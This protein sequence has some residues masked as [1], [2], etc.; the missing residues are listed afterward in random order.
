MLQRVRRESR[1]PRLLTVHHRFKATVSSFISHSLHCSPTIVEMQLLEIGQTSKRLR[2]RKRKSFYRWLSSAKIVP[3]DRPNKERKAARCI[4]VLCRDELLGCRFNVA[5]YGNE[6]N[7][8]AWLLLK[9]P[10]FFFLH[11]TL[12]LRK[13]LDH[14]IFITFAMMCAV[15]WRLIVCLGSYCANDLLRKTELLHV[16]G[17]AAL[18]RDVNWPTIAMETKGYRVAKET[19]VRLI[20]VHAGRRGVFGAVYGDTSMALCS[21][22]N[23]Q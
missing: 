9:C 16:S 2:E 6:T 23:R 22:E 4:S 12:G 1:T 7:A 20:D 10:L 11:I 5:W 19:S 15:W 3:H 13:Q 8:T 18:Q 14:K 17:T 21:D